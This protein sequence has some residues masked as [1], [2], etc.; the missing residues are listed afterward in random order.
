MEE[1]IFGGA[2]AAKRPERPVIEAMKRG[3]L[4]RCPHCGQ[5]RLFRAFLKTADQC[6]VCGEEFHHHRAD[7]L[8]A[9]LVVFIVGHIVVGG[10]MGMEAMTDWP[11]WLHLAIWVPITLIMALALIGPIKG[12]VVG[13]QWAYYMHG[14]GGEDDA[15]ETHPEA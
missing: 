14:F 9:Y 5:G 7:D 1:Q 12:A 3:F 15:L 6:Q 10:F 13:L 11:G 8:P 4:G 2:S